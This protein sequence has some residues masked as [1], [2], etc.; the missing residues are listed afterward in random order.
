MYKLQ[1]HWKNTLVEK[2]YKFLKKFVNIYKNLI[3]PHELE[4]T[5]SKN[6]VKVF[7]FDGEYWWDYPENGG[8]KLLKSRHLGKV[9]N[10]KCWRK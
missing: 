5:L 3:S 8:D 1:Y 4:F 2:E 9:V 10:Y 7:M 6:G